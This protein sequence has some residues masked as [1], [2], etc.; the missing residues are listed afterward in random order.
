MR[1]SAAC[2]LSAAIAVSACADAAKPEPS[3]TTAAQ[4]T[5]EAPVNTA[6]ARATTTAA[7]HVA[8]T[9]ASAP[10]N[11]AAAAG[12]GARAAAAGSGAA[13]MS[14]MSAAQAGATAAMMTS[15]AGT[16]AAGTAASSGCDRNC[17][18]DVMKGY[19]DALVARDA[20]KLKVS[21]SLKYTENGATAKLGETVWTSAMSVV[22]GTML[23]FADPVEKN[24][25]SQF[26]FSESGSTQ[27]IYQVRL[28]VDEGAI[29][30]I[31]SMVVKSGDQF[32]NPAGMKPEAVF[33]EMVPADKRA[34]R[35]KLMAMTE[36]YLGY[37]EG[38]KSAADVG[39]DT[40][41]K[42]YENGTVTA[43][44]LTAFQTQSWSF[45]VT[46][47]IL[48]VDEEAGITW[49]MFPFQQSESALVVGEAFKIFGDKIMMIQ[50]VMTYMPSKAWD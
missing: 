3:T 11:M 40:M 21:S 8:S 9:P 13:G 22:D 14:G 27:K 38:K 41:C 29:I 4:A 19:V 50:A 46:H 25:A 5:S 15:A 42:R 28:K 33:L 2:M 47:R 24:V 39:F 20:S 36:L 43:N 1:P 18:L 7:G 6:G 26:V 32:F 10:Q 44:G 45:Q 12:V 37:L 23:T 35:D 48:V 31:E 17:L 49:G 30:E 34:T 16:G